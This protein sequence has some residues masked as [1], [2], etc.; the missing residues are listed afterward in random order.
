MDTGGPQRKKR[1]FLKEHE[2]GLVRTFVKTYFERED[3]AVAAKVTYDLLLAELRKEYPNFD[4]QQSAF[5]K[6]AGPIERWKEEAGIQSNNL[7]REYLDRLQAV[8]LEVLISLPL[9]TEF[10]SIKFHELLQRAHERYP[11]LE[12]KDKNR[13][14]LAFHF[15]LKELKG[16]A[17][18]RRVQDPEV[19]AAHAVA[20]AAAVIDGQCPGESQGGLDVQDD[21]NR[22]SKRPRQH[23]VFAMSSDCE[24]S[25]QPKPS[26]PKGS[27]AQMAPEFD[28]PAGA[29]S[30]KMADSDKQESSSKHDAHM[31]DAD[32][33]ES[34]PKEGAQEGTCIQ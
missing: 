30:G 24:A 25:P 5:K 22:A 28:A 16:K 1:V 12:I 4:V 13:N 20:A 3:K 32:K 18:E 17:R 21:R 33:Q 15:R 29:D 6:H 19:P 14:T 8:F 10:E 27:N 2:W 34:S 11:E 26:A 31:A 23:D 7:G 9:N